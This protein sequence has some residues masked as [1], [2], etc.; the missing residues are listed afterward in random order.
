MQSYFSPLRKR[1]VHRG[2]YWTAIQECNGNVNRWLV[3]FCVQ[4][5]W[6]ERQLF[7]IFITNKT[8]KVRMCTLFQ[9]V[10]LSYWKPAH[11][12]YNFYTF[13]VHSVIHISR[14]WICSDTFQTARVS[15]PTLI[16]AGHHIE[17]RV[18]Q[19]G[20]LEQLQKK[21]KK[22]IEQWSAYSP[23]WYKCKA[24]VGH[25]A[26]KPQQQSTHNPSADNLIKAHDRG[27]KLRLEPYSTR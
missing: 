24:A 25:R 13:K 5:K 1:S 23:H 20:N 19:S 22:R 17:N 21:Y 7:A 12:C 8:I 9:S 10:L 3:P 16:W 18:N 6:N 14:I 15:M 26:A 4:V 27:Y 2:S 11:I